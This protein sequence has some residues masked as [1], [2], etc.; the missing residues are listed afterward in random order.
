[1]KKLPEVLGEKL[2]EQVKE[3]LN[4]S[5]VLVEKEEYFPKDRID[6]I[7][8]QNKALKEQLIERDTQLN[9]LKEKAQGSDELT[10]KIAELEAKNQEVA[11]RYEQELKSRQKDYAIES[12][13]RDHGARNLR[14]VKALLDLEKVDLEGEK[15]RG[16][17][18][19]IEA[20]RQENDYLFLNK[21]APLPPKAG[22]S[23][24]TQQSGIVGEFDDLLKL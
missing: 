20:L 6:E 9:Q 21:Q 1:M 12:A 5:F 19:Q 22:L 10:A 16:L 11:L 15:V 3:K 8:S 13:L 23:S 4:D 2:F 7:N 18:E 14:A 24:R 17:D